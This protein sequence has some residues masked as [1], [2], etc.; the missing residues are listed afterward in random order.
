MWESDSSGRPGAP[1][2]CW[3]NVGKRRARGKVTVNR[4]TYGDM[5]AKQLRAHVSQWLRAAQAAARVSSIEAS[6]MSEEARARVLASASARL[7]AQ[8]AAFR[9]LAAA[10]ALPDFVAAFRSSMDERFKRAAARRR[11][12]FNRAGGTAAGRGRGDGSPLVR[13]RSLR[14][15]RVGR[16]LVRP[17]VVVHSFKLAVAVPYVREGAERSRYLA[18]WTGQ[19]G[20]ALD[21]AAKRLARGV[22]SGKVSATS[23]EEARAAARAALIVDAD[24]LVSSGLH[25]SSAVRIATEDDQACRVAVAA[26]RASLRGD[27]L[28]GVKGRDSDMSGRATLDDDGAAGVVWSIARGEWVKVRRVDGAAAIDQAGRMVCELRGGV[29]D[30]TAARVRALDAV[31]LVSWLASRRLSVRGNW[32][33]GCRARVR[34]SAARVARVLRALA[35]GESLALACVAVGWAWNEQR[36]CCRAW[37]D[38]VSAL[39]DGRGLAEAFADYRS[40]RQA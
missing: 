10:G 11:A 16:L 27:A 17:V 19:D 36:N 31:R 6:G 12:R 40:D 34:T 4:E 8:A 38:A 1:L 9:R 5:T 22:R 25:W 33:N 30:D 15:D 37:A 39:T 2:V 7:A 21:S 20:A 32:S 18:F 26:A 35:R 23:A 24:R 13:V 14:L 3:Q 28:G 29:A